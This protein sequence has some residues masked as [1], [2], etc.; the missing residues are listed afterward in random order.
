[1]VG[2]SG[3]GRVVIVSWGLG[4]C[5]TVAGRAYCYYVGVLF[6]GGIW[7]HDIGVIERGLFLRL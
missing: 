3:A 5:C 4:F 7:D 2:K 1:M 6:R